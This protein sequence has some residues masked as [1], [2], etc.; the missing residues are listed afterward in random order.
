[1]RLDANFLYDEVRDGFFVP[2]TIKCSWACQ[3]E[4]LSDIDELCK[5]NNITYYAEWG[6]LL[7][8]VRHEGFIPWDDDLDI[9]MKRSDYNKFLSVAS[10]L[11]ANYKL[12]NFYNEPEYTDYMTRVVNN[13]GISFE[14]EHLDKYYGFPFV[15]GIDIFVLDYL[16]DDEEKLNE[17]LDLVTELQ[18][19]DAGISSGEMNSREVNGYLEKIDSVLDLHGQSKLHFNN[20]TDFSENVILKNKIR[21]AIDKIFSLYKDINNA[22][23]ITL[24]P[25]YY[26]NRSYVFPAFY[27]ENII[28]LKYEDFMMPVPAYYDAILTKKYGEYIKTVKKG[29]SHDYPFYEHQEKILEENGQKWINKCNLVKKDINEGGRNMTAKRKEKLFEYVGILKELEKLI[30]KAVNT[31]D[32][33]FLSILLQKAQEI[34]ISMGN[35]IEQTEGEGFV[36]VKYLEEYCELI[37]KISEGINNIGDISRVIDKIEKSVNEDVRVYKEVVFLPYKASMWDSLEGEWKKL[38]DNL[39]IKTF[40]IPIP[41]YDKNPDGSAKEMHYEAELF[42]KDVPITDY[43]NYNLKQRHPDVIYI[44]NPYDECNYVTSVH[45]YFYSKNI[46]EYT[47]ELIYIPYFVLDEISPDDER[48]IKNIEHFCIAPAIFHADKVIVQSENM[49]KVYIENLVRNVGENT[50]TVWEKKIFGWGSP[51]LD[52]VKNTKKE[53]IVIPDAWKKKIFDKEGKAKKVILYNTSVS[54][55]I[56]NGSKMID[57]MKRVFEIFKNNPEVVL[58]WRPHPLVT[59]TLDS[60]RPE[61]SQE[62]R[63]LIEEYKN[64]DFGIYDDAPDLNASIAL[65]DAYFGDRSSLVQLFK[66]VGKPIMIENVNV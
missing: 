42:P 2:C 46:K 17:M 49:R 20:Y 1:M 10:D 33:N 50:R 60:M 56:E 32:M 22:K 34:A 54:A 35:Y 59:A 63:K 11:P 12:L 3:L 15:A 7:G 23:E 36:T 51:K 30:E 65:S 48:A 27:Y 16:P 62:Y 6:T 14:K 66:A 43:N 4:I 28:M 19:V 41:Y 52:K 38:K 39:E 64:A 57:K 5:K 21:I 25:I 31:A 53:D 29:G 61:I 55:F 47:D 37:Y 44:H 40:V 9:C 8:T 18:Y 26:K 45:P 24:M 58:L 13:S